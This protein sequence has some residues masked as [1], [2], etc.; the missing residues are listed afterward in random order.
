MVKKSRA[1]IQNQ[2]FKIN[3]TVRGIDAKQ[4]AQ[5]IVDYL[6]S[7]TVDSTD[8]ATKAVTDYLG[9]T[10]LILEHEGKSKETSTLISTPELAFE[11]TDEFL[12]LVEELKKHGAQGGEGC[13]I[14]FF[15][16]IDHQP[17]RA[18][19]NLKNIVASKSF[20]LEKAL[21]CS[22]AV[23]DEQSNTETKCTVEVVPCNVASNLDLGE[24]KACIQLECAISAQ[25][26][27]QNR[28]K[29][30]VLHPENEKYAF[31][32]WLNRMELKSD[33]YKP[34][35]MLFLKRLK[36]DASYKSGRTTAIAS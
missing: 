3:L 16:C 29:A 31:R 21:Q 34:M 36:G 19:L 2:R 7:C 27:N 9:R 23:K 13:G 30:E 28:A 15:A 11:D 10:W 32:C 25:A 33:E 24:M 35:R 20:L 18:V 26:V 6:P 4:T 1:T 14:N 17:E 5:A 12:Y 8:N 22:F